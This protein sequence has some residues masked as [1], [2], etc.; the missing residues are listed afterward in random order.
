MKT[1]GESPIAVNLGAPPQS[2]R[3]LCQRLR[4]LILPPNAIAQASAIFIGIVNARLAPSMKVPFLGTKLRPARH[5]A[6]RR[7]ESAVPIWLK[8]VIICFADVRRKNLLVSLAQFFNSVE[9][10]SLPVFTCTV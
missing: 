4:W 5:I 1:P 7:L 6:R 3:A 9:V 2:I 10:G 8:V